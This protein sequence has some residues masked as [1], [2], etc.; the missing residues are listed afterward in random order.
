MTKKKLF[1]KTLYIIWKTAD[2]K[3]NDTFGNEFSTNIKLDRTEDNSNWAWLAKLRSQSSHRPTDIKSSD[4]YVERTKEKQKNKTI[5]ASWLG[6]AE[7]TESLHFLRD[8]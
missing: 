8:F 1:H 2:G 5:Y 6:Q 7:E 3:C 4:Q